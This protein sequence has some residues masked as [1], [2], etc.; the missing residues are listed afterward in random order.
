MREYVFFRY[1]LINVTKIINT[2]H[3]SITKNILPL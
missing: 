1:M 2:Q 3:P